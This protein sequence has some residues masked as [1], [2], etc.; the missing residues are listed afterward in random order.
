MVKYTK[1]ETLFERDIDGAKQLIPWKFRNPA[2]EYLANNQWICTEKIDGT[3]IGIVWDG[4]NITFQGRTEKAEIPKHLLSYLEEKFLNDETEQLFE[5]TFGEKNVILFG[6]GYGP[7]IQKGGL[8]RKDVSFILFDIYVVNSNI[9]LSRKDVKEIGGVFDLDVVPII[10]VGTIYDAVKYI[11]DSP[12]S[13]IGTAPMEGL[14][15]RPKTELLDR[16]GKR[17]LVKVK[18]KDLLPIKSEL[19]ADLSLNTEHHV[20]QEI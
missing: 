10:L 13:T 4:Y 9:W 17:I 1:I 14:V 6:E 15:C 5:Q 16:C 3:N 2:V 20:W 18:V 8:Y 11:L 7:K 12:K 19:A